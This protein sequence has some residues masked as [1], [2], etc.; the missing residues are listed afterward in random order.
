[1]THLEPGQVFAGHRIGGLI[2]EGGMGMVYLA[3]HLRLHRRVALKVVRPELTESG[4]YRARFV[5]EAELAASI[6]HPNIIPVYDA[7]ESDGLLYIAMRYVDGRNLRTVI[8][9]EAPLDP[10]WTV[11]M[12]RQIAGAL[13]AAH[14]QGLVHRDVKPANILLP[15]AG[16]TSADFCYLTDFG[17]TKR[18]QADISLTGTGFF[19][20]TIDYAAPEQIAARPIDGRTDLYALGCVMFECLTGSKPFARESELAVLW[21]HLNEPPPRPSSVRKDLGGGWDAVIARALAKEPADRF[22]D[23]AS[24]GAA[25]RSALFTSGEEQGAPFLVGPPPPTMPVPVGLPIPNPA[26]SPSL[27]AAASPPPAASSPSRPAPTVA[28][29]GSPS[30]DDR[31]PGGTPPS[32]NR[33]RRRARRWPVVAGI[34]AL[35]VA[36]AVLVLVLANSPPGTDGGHTTGPTSGATTSAQGPVARAEA[37]ERR[38]VALVNQGPAANHAVCDQ[39]DRISRWPTREAKDAFCGGFRRVQRST[40]EEISGRR[41]KS[42]VIV[43]FTTVT[44]QTDPGG[45]AT[46]TFDGVRAIDPNRGLIVDS[47]G[48]ERPTA[49]GCS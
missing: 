10:A 24:M 1:M 23:C 46:H 36:G 5:Q 25:A 42:L 30:R 33:P 38:F 40:L 8:D 13:D 49:P 43:R 39:L 22:P 21:A 27:A 44:C 48:S 29:R 37:V 6:E 20:G 34:A 28:P 12:I 11:W 41:S 16:P 9:E 31:G 45:L 19:L 7:G 26:S 2:G 18:T 15:A 47:S 4:D 14:A 17:L 3:E 32:R 35:V